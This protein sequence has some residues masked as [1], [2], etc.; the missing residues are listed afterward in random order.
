MGETHELF[1][2]ALWFGLP[3]RL[4]NE[5]RN[6]VFSLRVSELGGTKLCSHMIF[7]QQGW[8]TWWL[9]CED[10]RLWCSLIPMRSGLC[11]ALSLDPVV[12]VPQEG[13]SVFRDL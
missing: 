11:W 4:L 10:D 5:A 9:L 1:M 12:G 2:L 7:D 13:H 6:R 3:G 8:P